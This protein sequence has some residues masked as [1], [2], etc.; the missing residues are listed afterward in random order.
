M[1]N[2]V[3]IDRPAAARW[4][5]LSVLRVMMVG[6]RPLDYWPHSPFPDSS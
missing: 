1:L 6:A 3:A 2:I 5:H 4:S